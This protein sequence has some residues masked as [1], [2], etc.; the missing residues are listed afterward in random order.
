[1]KSSQIRE[2]F[3][4][5][6]K[7]NNHKIVHSSPLVPQNDPTLM[8][9][10]SGMVQFKN[11]FTGKETRDYKRAVTA[12]K[13]V[14]AGGK[15]NDLENVGYTARH[16]TFFEMLGN[17]SFGD[18]FKDLAI[19]LAWNLIVKEFGI[20]KNKLLVTVFD[21]DEEAFILWKKIAGLS[22]NKILKISTSDNFWSMGE[23]GP[24][25]PCSEIF[26]DHGDCYAGGPPG[27]ENEEGD[28][29]IEIWN[30]VFMQYEQISKDI[31][32]DLPKP[33]IDTGMGLERVSA[34]LQNTNDD[35]ATD[36]FIPLINKSVELTNL[37]E[38]EN[39]A[40]HRVIA[41][42]LRSASFLI[43]DGV[44]PSNEGR[45]YV[46]RRIMRRGMRHAHS[47]GN[48]EPI[49]HKIFPTLLYEMKDSYP[50]LDRAKDL[51]LNILLNEETKFKQTIDNGM[52]I[53][54]DEIDNTQNNLFSGEVAFKLYDTYGFPLDLTQDYLKNKKILVDIDSFDKKMEEQKKRARQSWKG[55]GDLE[56]NKIWLEITEKIQSTEFLG[57]KQPGSESI[58]LSLI[59]NNKLVDKLNNGEEGII[60]LNQTPFYGESGGQVGDNGYLQ[61]ENFEFN[62]NNTTKIF[63]NYHLHWGQ[64]IKGSCKK[65]DVLEAS[66]D[67]NRR[68]LIKCNHSST[69]LLHSALRKV[70]GNHIFQKGS[71]VNDEKL[72]FD[73]SHNDTISYE[74]LKNIELLVNKIIKQKSPVQTEIQDHNEAVNSGAIALFGEK[75]GDEV[76]VVTMGKDRDNIFSIE[77][78]GGTHV[79]NTEDIE[80]FKIINQSSIAS[81]VRRI[82]ALTNISVNRFNRD[83]EIKQKDITI[84]IK[85]EINK[86]IDLIKDIN[87][88]KK[89]NIDLGKNLEKQLKEIK[90]IY[91]DY[92]QNVDIVKNKENIKIEKIGSYNLIYLLANNYPGKGLK[93]FI[94]EQKKSHPK[95][96]IIV[97]VSTDQNKVSIIVGI[98]DDLINIYDATN[99]V[100]VASNIVGGKGGGGRKDLAQAG[101]HKP[102]NAD[103]IYD[104]IKKEVL[105]LS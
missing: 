27:S 82:E 14:R 57:Y 99:I 16:H 100:K 79:N 51:I 18:Y 40:S 66:I 73:F 25:G 93:L 89:Y 50:E 21:Q 17:F 65:G 30:L 76:R 39:S 72:R 11:V 9:A 55:T 49:F 96:S 59:S 33:S 36:I 97:L 101:G 70:L 46:L 78:C 6:F 12:Q 56:E 98:T 34:L 88:R 94:D 35:Y 41:D 62:V 74:N 90:K 71:L 52:K 102:D 23:T 5:Y 103:K 4:S 75:Y 7:K 86:Y 22:E 38:K 95:E 15:H 37:E 83:Q 24:C 84:Q 80:K 69:H 1:M 64:V 91:N 31:R 60:I 45:G 20:D 32:E 3:L 105:K 10:N 19:E 26:Y 47:L 13:C 87:P 2:T 43:S 61:N 77:L 42:H 104:E 29:F 53:L 54:E 67:Y 85:N 68:H 63:G 48:K 44:L 81:G 28:R 58:I 92:K 8:F